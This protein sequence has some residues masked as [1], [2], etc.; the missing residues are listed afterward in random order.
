MNIFKR[1]L[2]IGLKALLIWSIALVAVLS[3]AMFEYKALSTEMN[4]FVGLFPRILLVIMGMN[5]AVDIGTAPGFFSML[6]YYFI[7][8]LIF[9]SIGQGEKAVIREIKDKTHEFLFVKPISRSKILQF[10][11]ISGIIYVLIINTVILLAS[12]VSFIILKEDIG[13]LFLFYITNTL[14]SLLFFSLTCFCNALRNKTEKGSQPV[15]IVFLISFIVG[16]IYDLLE[17]GWYVQFLTPIK[18]FTA[19]SLVDYKISIFYT[20]FTIL[21]SSI[22]LYFSIYYF[23]KKELKAI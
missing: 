21:V 3:I 5:P 17:N 16:I 19:S 13:V 8:C 22:S 12:I 18:Y 15:Y 10:K 4:L 2:K 1:E 14:V 20:F 7:I 6:N 11:I 23:N 9:F